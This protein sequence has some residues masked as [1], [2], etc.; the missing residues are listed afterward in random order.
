MWLL[1]IPLL[2]LAALYHQDS[3]VGDAG[4]AQMFWALMSGNFLLTTAVVVLGI[5]ILVNGLARSLSR[6]QEQARQLAATQEATIDTVTSLAEYRDTETGNH[7]KRT[8]N[9]VRILAER[10][11]RLPKYRDQLDRE[12]IDLLYLSAPLHDIG[13]VG[14]PDRILLKPGKLTAEEFEEMKRHAGYGRDALLQSER[15]LGSNGFLRLAAELAYSHHEKWDGSGYPEGLAGD[16]IPLSGRIVALADV[17]DALVSR[18][19]YKEPMSHR[20][21]MEYITGHAGTHFDPDL[22][23][24]LQ[25][26]EQAFLEIGARFSDESISRGEFPQQFT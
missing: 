11:A 4:S 5:N 14:V 23:V 7:I 21:A 13:K 26:E 25:A 17:Y 16:D 24:A 2:L 10:L 18:R 9:Y 22:V 19:C 20:E 3:Y 6:Q 1:N 12:T 15:K 8:Q